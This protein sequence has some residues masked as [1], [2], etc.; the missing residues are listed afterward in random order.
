MV[1]FGEEGGDGGWG[2]GVGD[3]EVAVLFVGGE[4][5]GGELCR[6]A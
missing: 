1:G 4:L 5:L 3:E 6:C 2:E